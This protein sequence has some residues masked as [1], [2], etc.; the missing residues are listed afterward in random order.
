MVHRRL[1]V[2]ATDAQTAADAVALVDVDYEELPELLDAPGGA[3]RGRVAHPPRGQPAASSSIIRRASLI[4]RRA[5]DVYR[6]DHR[7][8][9]RLRSTDA[10]DRTTCPCL[11]DYDESGKLTI[12]S[13]TQ[14]VFGA[15]TVV[16]DLFGLKDNRV[17][18]IKAPMGGS[19][20]G[21][22]EFILEPVTAFMA[23][24]TKRPVKLVL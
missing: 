2:V 8:R 14:S 10:A 19:F 17:R 16:A 11:A 21:K 4:A 7:G 18:V 5:D 23:M 1:A 15:R 12:W 13:P 6:D 3:A 22:Q 24:F 20:G 9:Y